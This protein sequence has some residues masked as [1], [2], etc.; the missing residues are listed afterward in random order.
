MMMTVSSGSGIMG[1]D[2]L[3]EARVGAG[4]AEH[5]GHVKQLVSKPATRMEEAARSQ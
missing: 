2:G 1:V 4:V 3:T 5:I